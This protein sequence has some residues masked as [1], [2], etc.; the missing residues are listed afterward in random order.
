MQNELCFQITV[1]LSQLAHPSK[2]AYLFYL[3]ISFH[4]KRSC[5]CCTSNS[6]VWYFK[7]IIWIKWK[8]WKHT[9]YF[10]YNVIKLWNKTK[11]RTSYLVYSYNL[12]HN[13]VLYLSMFAFIRLVCI[14]IL[15]FVRISFRQFAMDKMF[16]WQCNTQD[17][18]ICQTSVELFSL[19][20]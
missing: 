14:L 16:L 3:M 9:W 5:T 12:L 11:K 4:P 15:S 20:T 7:E 10:L 2:Y 19:M 1:F 6:F 8:I 17:T 13:F 18:E